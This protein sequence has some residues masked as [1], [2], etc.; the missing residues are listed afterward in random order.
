[1]LLSCGEGTLSKDISESKDLSRPIQYRIVE[2]PSLLIMLAFAYAILQFDF[3]TNIIAGM[4]DRYGNSSTV[5]EMS[6]EHIPTN[7]NMMLLRIQYYGIELLCL[8][9]LFAVFA[10]CSRITQCQDSQIPKADTNEVSQETQALKLD[11]AELEQ[12]NA[13]LLEKLGHVTR[14]LKLCE[15]SFRS[16]SSTETTTN[17]TIMS[18]QKQHHHDKYLLSVKIKELACM[19]DQFDNL[20]NL[21]TKAQKELA[22]RLSAQSGTS[23]D[24]HEKKVLSQAVGRP[25]N[26]HRRGISSSV[27]RKARKG[28]EISKLQLSLKRKEA[29]YNKLESLYTH[30]EKKVARQDGCIRE[31]QDENAMLI[32]SLVEKENELKQL[33]SNGLAGQGAPKAELA[34]APNQYQDQLQ[35]IEELQKIL[36]EK[37]GELMD[38]AAESIEDTEENSIQPGNSSA[39][40]EL[41]AQIEAL[42]T[43]IEQ[44]KVSGTTETELFDSN[45]DYSQC[46]FSKMDRYLASNCQ[47]DFGDE[48]QQD[49]LHD[50]DCIE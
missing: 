48:W 19:R 1:M 33:H 42:K 49:G 21:L 16:V 30:L 3:H 25:N 28:S 47:N 8:T 14:D 37:E 2:M 20:G 17:E 15:R 4:L 7:A 27:I 50:L 45:V 32:S 35:T 43:A 40:D 11:K 23:S 24:L 26:S 22:L 13:D 39:L 6:Y 38:L 9:I 41:K 44:K 29:D 12:R 34:H 18:Y 31:K 5:R 10:L 46:D 36:E